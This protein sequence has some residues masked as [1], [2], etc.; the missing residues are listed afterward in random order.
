MNDEE[1]LFMYFNILKIRQYTTLL[2]ICKNYKI[3]VFSNTVYCFRITDNFVP[4]FWLVFYLCFRH[5]KKYGNKIN[6][7]IFLIVF[8]NFHHDFIAT[9]CTWPKAFCDRHIP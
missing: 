7:A 3:F 4:V 5:I 1:E 2:C 8:N 9:D 6:L